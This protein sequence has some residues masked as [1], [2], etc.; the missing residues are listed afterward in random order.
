MKYGAKSKKIGFVMVELLVFSLLLGAILGGVLE[1]VSL[2]VE[3]ARVVREKRS[4]ALVFSSLMS[5]IRA[6]AAE[7]NFDD[8]RRRIRISG[9]NAPLSP[10]TV[11][12]D[13]VGFGVAGDVA[14]SWTRRDIRCRE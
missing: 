13:A 7:E 1:V 4:D 3:C 10:Q 11:Q 9:G 8:G 14:L 5:E 2:A 6:G 12:V